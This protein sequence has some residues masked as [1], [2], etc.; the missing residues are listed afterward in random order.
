MITSMSNAQ[1]KELVQLMEKGRERNRTKTFICEGLK[2]YL[3]AKKAGL[4]VKVF[5]SETF[6]EHNI[7][8][9]PDALV[10]TDEVFD[11]VS[12]TVTPQGIL[13]VVNMPEYDLDT[14]I[15]KKNLKIIAL[16]DLRDPGNIGT[17]IRTAEG[18]GMDLVL[19]SKGCVDIFNPKVV[20]ST[21]GTIF[22]V[23]FVYVQ[24]FAD[25]IRK[26]K[27]RGVRIYAA[28]LEGSVDYKEISGENGKYSQAVMI[29][30]EANG[31]TEETAQI[32]DLKVRIPMDGK[33]ESLNAAV[34]AAILMYEM[35]R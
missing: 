25:S 16:E 24:N 22:R 21:M 34:A 2:V 8:F 18:A 10:L 29:G 1:V 33:V 19:M 32:A 4:V 14:V 26:L 5:V 3:E 9:E 28:Y 20:R 30:N 35:K 27:E 6:R 15:L 7:D 17:V 31:L 13:A 23:P 12:K 11:S